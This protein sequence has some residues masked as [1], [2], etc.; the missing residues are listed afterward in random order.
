MGRVV[1]EGFSVCE[2]LRCVMYNGYLISYGV[3]TEVNAS[4][5]GAGLKLVAVNAE[6]FKPALSF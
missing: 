3:M 2:G 5:L 6:R 4:E 1:S